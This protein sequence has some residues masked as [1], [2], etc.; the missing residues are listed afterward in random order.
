MRVG[1]AGLIRG[2]KTS[3]NAICCVLLKTWV[4]MAPKSQFGHCR[5]KSLRLGAGYLIASTDIMNRWCSCNV[6]CR[7]QNV[8]SKPFNQ[9]VMRL[10]TAEM[11]GSKGSRHWGNKKKRIN[12]GGFIQRF[13][14]K[15]RVKSHFKSKNCTGTQQGFFMQ[16]SMG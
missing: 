12:F 15:R 8:R 10:S 5:G 7:V 1:L 3:K 6:C 4:L 16:L 2:L 11:L 9:L 13:V 14:F